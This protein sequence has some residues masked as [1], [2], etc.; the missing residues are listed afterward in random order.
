MEY[1]FFPKFY[2]NCMAEAVSVTPLYSRVQ[3]FLS[4]YGNLVVMD[5]REQWYF[6][7]ELD[8]YH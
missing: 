1:F 6:S 7:L 4:A 3:T 5:C 8:G 2:G